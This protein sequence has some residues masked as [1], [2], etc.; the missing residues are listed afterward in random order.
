MKNYVRRQRVF[1]PKAGARRCTSE[2]INQDDL[3]WRTRNLN[4]RV[5]LNKTAKR[6]LHFTKLRFAAVFSFRK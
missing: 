3:L 2:R 6:I 5:R 1:V 4:V